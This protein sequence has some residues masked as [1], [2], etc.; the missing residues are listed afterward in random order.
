VKNFLLIVLAGVCVWL[1]IER[2][3]LTSE[4]TALVEQVAK[5]ENQGGVAVAGTAAGT[6]GTA[7]GTSAGAGQAAG[8]RPPATGPSSNAAGR[9]W[10]DAHIDKGARALED[11]NA[12][13]RP[14][15]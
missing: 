9:S 1:L 11:P 2:H 10:L 8:S 5:Y 14:R 15:R 6:P 7:A 13:N 4:V 12:K 3:R